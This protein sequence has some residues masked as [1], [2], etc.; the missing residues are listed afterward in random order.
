MADTWE[1]CIEV[2]ARTTKYSMAFPR[3]D[4]S[5]PPDGDDIGIKRM[6]YVGKNTD[7]NGNQIPIL[8]NGVPCAPTIVDKGCSQISTCAELCFSC[9]AC[10]EL[11]LLKHGEDAV[12]MKQNWSVGDSTASVTGSITAGDCDEEH[13]GCQNGALA[14][15][16]AINSVEGT[17]EDWSPYN[18]I[19][20][21]PFDI[22]EPHSFALECA[23][24]EVLSI[25]IENCTYRIG[26]LTV[27]RGKTPWYPGVSCA[28]SAGEMN[29]QYNEIDIPVGTSS[30]QV[31]GSFSYGVGGGVYDEFGTAICVFYIEGTVTYDYTLN[32]PVQKSPV[33]YPSARQFRM[34]NEFTP[35]SPLGKAVLID[36][37][38]REAAGGITLH[39]LGG[40]WKSDLIPISWFDWTQF[41][42][43]FPAETR[44]SHTGDMYYQIT[45][46][47]QRST[48]YPL[49]CWVDGII[50]IDAVNV[51]PIFDGGIDDPESVRRCCWQWITYLGPRKYCYTTDLTKYGC[52]SLFELTA[53]CQNYVDPTGWELCGGMYDAS[54]VCKTKYAWRSLG[55]ESWCDGSIP[56]ECCN[57]YHCPLEIGLG[58][59]VYYPEE[60]TYEIESPFL[61]IGG[62]YRA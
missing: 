20:L 62:S 35:C 54:T 5:H 10:N 8:V 33:F 56:N 3:E 7:E 1:E 59:S 57:K 42:E 28:Y 26:V 23:S 55:D 30:I 48:M 58:E 9:G 31:I 40:T 61:G 51:R 17:L 41:N 11:F 2:G 49:S 15:I 32:I 21:N 34:D 46:W 44:I 6:V 24:V 12:C 50:Q 43:E 13:S 39:G 4:F 16:T 38:A 37:R 36:M 53:S 45:L 29:Y 27:L 22:F 14:V 60:R 18:C 52:T 25:N 47:E 19:W